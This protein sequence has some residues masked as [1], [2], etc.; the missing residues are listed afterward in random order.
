MVRVK[1]GVFT[2]DRGA[3]RIVQGLTP[4]WWRAPR[5]VGVVR[6]SGSLSGYISGTKQYFETTELVWY[7]SSTDVKTNTVSYRTPN[8]TVRGERMNLDLATRH[9][10]F[11]GAVEAGMTELG[12]DDAG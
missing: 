9:I 7:M 3:T 5:V 10:T 6:I 4:W 2:Q 8:M 12:N 11:E 1:D